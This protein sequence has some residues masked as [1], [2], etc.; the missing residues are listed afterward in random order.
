VRNPDPLRHSF[1]LKSIETTLARRPL[2]ESLVPRTAIDEAFAQT[3][4]S[5]RRHPDRGR[6]EDAI[7]TPLLASVLRATGLY[8]IGMRNASR[9]VVREIDCLIDK[10]PPAFD[11]YRI[12]HLADLHIDSV[13]GLAQAVAETVGGLNAELVVM[14]GDYRFRTHGPCDAVWPGMR[15][16]L[17]ALSPADGVYGILGNHDSSDMAYPLEELGVQLLINDALPICRGSE[18]IWLAGVDD[19]Y[20]YRTDDLGRAL[21]AVPA[22]ACKVLLAHTPDLYEEANAAGI[23]VY[24]CGHTHAGQ[25]RLPLLGSVIQN[26]D[27]PRK[28]THGRWRHGRMHGYT[29]AGIGCSMLPI[30]F[31]CPPEVVRIHLRRRPAL[32]LQSART[33]DERH[34][35]SMFRAHR[36]AATC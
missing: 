18:S 16:I 14:T 21:E 20:D 6:F 11:G 35:V 30:R 9:L 2:A 26:S 7:V 29:S 33:R 4:K 5:F 13:P 10:L 22:Y 25:V 32:E 3:G 19:W 27:A 12:L 24:L 17:A 15:R 34:R 28:Y 23:D 36:P 1:T 31:N 8:A